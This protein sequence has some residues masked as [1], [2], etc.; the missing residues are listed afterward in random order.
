MKKSLSVLIDKSVYRIINI[1]L[2]LNSANQSMFMKIFANILKYK[3]LIWNSSPKLMFLS[4]KKMQLFYEKI[5]RKI[6][7]TVC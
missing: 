7:E 3:S 4:T 6:S 2:D 5:S 1:V